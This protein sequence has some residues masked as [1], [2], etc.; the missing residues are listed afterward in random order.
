MQLDKNQVLEESTKVA[1]QAANMIGGEFEQGVGFKPTPIKPI[2]AETLGNTPAFIPPTPKQSSAA[3]SRLEARVSPVE[4]STETPAATQQPEPNLRDTLVKRQLAALEQ[5]GTKGEKTQQIMEEQQVL[6]KQQALDLIDQDIAKRENYY[7]RR[8]ETLEDKGG[9]LQVGYESEANTIR[10]ERARELA[11]LY[12]ARAG[13]S[14]D[15]ETA[16]QY[17]N[18]LIAAEFEPLKDELKYTSEL[19]N[20]L[21]NDLT[22]SEKLQVQQQMTE[23]NNATE[24]AQSTSQQIYAEL[25]NSGAYTPERGQILKDAMAEAALAIKNGQ[26]PDAAIAK[27]QG[28]M[29]GVTTIGQLQMEAQRANIEQSRQATATARTNQLLALAEAGDPEAI[30]KLKFDPRTIEEEVDPV[31]RRQLESSL[32]SG[33]NLLRLASNYQK[34]IDDYGYTNRTFGNT[35]VLGQISSLRALMTA[36]YKKAETLGTLD[37]GVLALMSQIVG[38]EPTSGLFTPLTN[39]T[40]RRSDK[41]SAQL[42][43]FIENI[44]LAQAR[45]KA[46][47]GIEP[48]VDFS[49][50]SEEDDL[51]I[52][53]M[54]GVNTTT[55]QQGFNAATYFPKN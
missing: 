35:E 16:R 40:G 11:D 29:T 51:E 3:L 36:E 42:G 32:D 52:N 26:S 30:N 13:K 50:I 4:Q 53:S 38:E 23:K 21:A 31:T 6:E 39:A 2:P 9:G 48:S 46:R 15:V 25:I 5:L 28:T 41:L 54:M 45:D 27:M 55:P 10:R 19:Y 17:A 43:T 47:L 14:Q 44:T 12:I 33:T 8:L 7:T 22:E 18:D 49:V 24:L 34:L 20:M 37:A 1:K